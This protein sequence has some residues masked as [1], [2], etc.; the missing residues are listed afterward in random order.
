MAKEKEKLFTAALAKQFVDERVNDADSFEV[1]EHE[2]TAITNEAAEI[3]GNCKEDLSL[4][5]LRDLSKEAA[6]S[7]SKNKGERLSLI[8]LETI[9]DAVA[10]A[11]ADF[12]G[13]LALDQV[14]QLS[15]AA[16][17]SLRRHPGKLSLGITSLSDQAAQ[18]L[19][20]HVGPLEL[21]SLRELS[22]QAG[23]YLSRHTGGL[24]LSTSPYNGESE[25]ALVLSERAARNLVKYTGRFTLCGRESLPNNIQEI[26]A[27][28]P[29][30]EDLRELARKRVYG[31]D[32]NDTIT[33]WAIDGLLQM[34][35]ENRDL[36]VQDLDLVEDEDDA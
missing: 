16:A 2:F 9:S 30:D 7:L 3:L 4:E 20:Q 33:D 11:L 34:Y 28:L 26:L 13:E 23:C 25:T 19:C 31:C 36:Y 18:Y 15:D 6:V 8:G 35:R 17:E 1:N 32:D 14:S 21:L 5:S 10:E 24:S 22:E 27:P 12:N 29:N